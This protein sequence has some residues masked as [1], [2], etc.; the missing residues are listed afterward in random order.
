MKYMVKS[1]DMTLLC[2]KLLSL[3][4]N[5]IKTHGS[6]SCGPGVPQP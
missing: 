5:K 4:L 3:V 2:E 6:V 1:R